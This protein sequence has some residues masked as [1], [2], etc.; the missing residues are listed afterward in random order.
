MY[1]KFA[2]SG[3]IG[4]GTI[5]ITLETQHVASA[6]ASS[7]ITSMVVCAGILMRLRCDMMRS[8]A[9]VMLHGIVYVV[10]MMLLLT[11]AG[12]IQTSHSVVE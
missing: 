6:C 11:S 5:V 1:D 10:H 7:E 4:C 2:R 9:D 3:C 12:S 8:D